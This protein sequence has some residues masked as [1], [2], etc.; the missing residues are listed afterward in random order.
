[1]KCEVKYFGMISEKLDLTTEI[2]DAESVLSDV[3]DLQKSFKLRFPKLENMTFQIAVN[4]HISNEL[5]GEDVRT[6]ALLP[7]FAGG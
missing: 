4:G 2:I 7:P 1:M 6:I 3:K 5:S